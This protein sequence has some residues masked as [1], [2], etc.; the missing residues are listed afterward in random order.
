MILIHSILHKHPG[1]L[2]ILFS[3]KKKKKK[4]YEKGVHGYVS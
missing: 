3:S 4:L 1:K 2:I